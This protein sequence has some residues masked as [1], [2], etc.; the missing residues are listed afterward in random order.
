M[1]YIKLFMLLAVVSLFAACSS[2]DD[3]NTNEVT[4]GFANA[5][6]SF[7]ENAKV[8]NVPIK[9]SGLRNGKVSL[10]VKAEGVGN[11]PAQEDVNYMITD[12]TLNIDAEDAD[13]TINVEIIP[14][15]DNDLT[16]DRTFKLT[17]ESANGATIVNNSTTITITDNES[18]FYERFAGTWTLSGIDDEG[19]TFSAP[20]EMSSTTDE[21]KPE[22]NSIITASATNL[23]N[24]GVTLNFA[25]HFRYSFDATTKTGTLGF[26]CGEDVTSYSAY[27][28]TWV[29]ANGGNLSFDDVTATW[30]VGEDGNIPEIVFPENQKL[31]FYQYT[32]APSKGAWAYFDHLKLVKN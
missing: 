7:R 22:Y 21:S 31:Y 15:D 29:T 9:V 16:G 4:V 12:K 11:L 13:S 5:T 8:I 3:Y 28:W 30:T 2:D 14:I 32:Y 17:I 23:V 19:N 26:V 10:V 24:V 18:A 27:T 1:K 20:I 25:W 6:Q